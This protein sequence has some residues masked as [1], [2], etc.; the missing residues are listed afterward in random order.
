MTEVWA[1][2]ALWFGLALL[3]TL[4]AI[5]FRVSTALTEIIVG[6]LAQLIL[7]GVFGA[8]VLAT[9]T[10]WI[11]FL[12][13]AGAIVLTFLAGTELDPMAF[14]RSWKEAVAVGLVGFFAPVFGCAAVAHWILGWAAMQSWLA[15]VALSTTSVAVVY[16]VMLEYGPCARL[17]LCPLHDEDLCLCWHRNSGLHHITLADAAAVLSLWQSPFRARN[18]ISPFDTRWPWSTRSLVGQ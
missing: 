14:R 7:G 10:P 12:A 15:G 18:E 3:A 5:W 9:N 2:A 16:A 11:T 1:L 13:G 17:H 8:S 6:A 4:F